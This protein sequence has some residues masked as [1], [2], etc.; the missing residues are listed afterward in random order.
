MVR[1]I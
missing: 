1:Q